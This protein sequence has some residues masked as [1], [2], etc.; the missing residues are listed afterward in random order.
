VQ[1]IARR[2][3]IG[4]GTVYNHFSRKGDVLEALAWDRTAALCD[5]LGPVPGEP[6]GY[7]ARL[8]ARLDRAL[9]EVRRHRRFYALL[10]LRGPDSG[11]ART[12]LR[13]A[14]LAL[15]DE[16]LAAG[17]LERLPRE[18]LATLFSAVLGAAVEADLGDARLVARLFLDGARRKAGAP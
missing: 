3:R 15:V 1:D 4:V 2:A 17:A 12:R 8:T 10:L 5:R 6:R 16:G 9:G 7:R 18:G 13:A 14:V 11:R